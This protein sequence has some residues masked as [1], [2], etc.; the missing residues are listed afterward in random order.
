[1]IEAAVSS[2][3]GGRLAR[4]AGQA[5]MVDTLW[6]LGQRLKWEGIPNPFQALRPMPDYGGLAAATAALDVV[7]EW[8]SSAGLPASL[9]PL[10]IGVAGYGNV[11][12]GA[13]EILGRLPTIEVEPSALAQLTPDRDVSRH[14]IYKVVFKEQHMVE[15]LERPEQFL[16]Q[17]YY[18][19]P[20]KYRGIFARY[21]PNLT[22]LVNAIYWAPQYPRLVTKSYL[23]DLFGVDHRP[24]LRI[25]GDISCDVEGAI[26]ATT[27]STDS[28]S[29]VYVYDPS[30]GQTSDGYAGNGPVIMA[31]D[32]LPSELPRESSAEF[33]RALQEFAPALAAADFSANFDD[34]SLPSPVK[35]AVISHRGML[36]P[37]YQYLSQYLEKGS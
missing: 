33:S 6:A 11:S 3:S 19:Q 13:Q 24:K 32:I 8:I 5:G 36:T 21:L 28:G 18:D 2:S 16:L 31:V 29:P 35:R 9:V 23:A 25:I 12:I 34:L 1:M 7:G 15:R 30:S 27:R 37:D 22:V 4:Q 10:V 26:E 14:H 17:E 20:Q